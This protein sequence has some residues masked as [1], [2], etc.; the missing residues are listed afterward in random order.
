MAGR[1]QHYIPQSLQNGFTVSGTGKKPQLYQFSKN[2]KPFSSS[3]EG[4]GAMR[5]FYSKP[6]ADGSDALDDL[7]TEFEATF[8]GNELHKLRSFHNEQVESESAAILVAHLA[9]RTAHIRNTLAQFTDGALDQFRT[10]IKNPIRLRQF[11]GI[12]LPIQNPTLKTTIQTE[13]ESNG[14][15][16]YP[17]KYRQFI[18]RLVNFRL[19]ESFDEFSQNSD[20]F[21]SPILNLMSSELAETVARTQTKVLKDSMAPQARVNELIRLNWYVIDADN[22]DRHFILPDCVVVASTNF[23]VEF[24]PYT[25]S[26]SDTEAT[27]IVIMPIT[28]S[29]LLVGCKRPIEIDQSTLNQQFAKCSINFFISSRNDNEMLKIATSIGMSAVPEMISLFDEESVDVLG[30]RKVNHLK[31]QNLKIQVSTGK[32]GDSAKRFL[33]TI[34]KEVLNLEM[35]QRV[36]AISVPSNLAATLTKLKGRPPT[37]VELRSTQFGSVECV[38]IGTEWKCHILFPRSLIEMALQKESLKDQHLA[39]SSIK[40]TLGRIH[41]YDC[42]A[43]VYPSA[44]E[45]HDQILWDQITSSCVSYVASFYFGALAISDKENIDPAIDGSY[46]LATQLE[47]GLNGM[48][49]ARTNYFAHGSVPQLVHEVTYF[50]EMMMSILVVFTGRLN[51]H[52]LTLVQDSYAG[53]VLSEAGLW[54][55]SQLLIRDLKN[56]YKRRTIWQSKDELKQLVS[57]IERLFWTVGIVISETKNDYVFDV[58]ND[59]HLRKVKQMLAQTS[60]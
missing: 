47:F 42:W 2:L 29:Q 56:H 6:I 14:L 60:F 3:T 21:V 35:I 41:Y 34:S 24:K 59:Q 52:H 20:K 32:F 50:V 46:D 39:I 9:I 26:D 5:D 11:I 8:L 25:F 49:I 15:D 58:M 13:L 40:L 51:K 48:T 31:S 7:I 27:E 19:R 53:K 28:S 4:T 38:K 22:S 23:N 43:R 54:N 36:D 18:E 57:H 37:D 45:N 1:K 55:W 33:Q 10:L 17:L 44:F 12:D 30:L 16:A